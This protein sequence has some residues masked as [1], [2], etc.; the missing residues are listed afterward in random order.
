MVTKHGFFF[1]E[2][3]IKLLKVHIF[4]VSREPLT[5]IDVVA[6][7]ETQLKR[8]ITSR[9]SNIL[10]SAINIVGSVC[11]VGDDTDDTYVVDYMSDVWSYNGQNHGL[12]TL[13]FAVFYVFHVS[14][15]QSAHW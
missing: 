3:T 15:F 11:W 5:K 10:K 12:L 4:K 13:K 7:S 2:L 8:H 6:K 14:R 1:M 9:L